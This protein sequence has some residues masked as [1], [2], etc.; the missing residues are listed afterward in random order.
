M[1]GE[2]FPSL[3]HLT[4]DQAVD[5]LRSGSITSVDLVN[6]YLARI[7]EVNGDLKAVLQINSDALAIARELD[8]ERLESGAR[9]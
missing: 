8:E 7:A 4:L 6:A 3:L 9:R 1:T 5:G 2:G